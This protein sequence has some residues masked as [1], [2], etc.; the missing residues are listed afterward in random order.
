MKKI[1][2]SMLFAAVLAFPANTP[3]FAGCTGL[4]TPRNIQKAYQVNTRSPDG[5]PGPGYWQNRADYSMDINFDPVTRI[6][7]GKETITYYNNSPDTLKELVL[8]LFPDYFKKGNARDETIAE[9]DESPGV[10]IEQMTVNNN[11]VDISPGRGVTDEY[12]STPFVPGRKN[13][14]PALVDIC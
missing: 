14:A 11:P 4:Y 3:A 2:I 7:K 12:R 10:T 13:V 6:L 8:H 1:V 9:T 5:K